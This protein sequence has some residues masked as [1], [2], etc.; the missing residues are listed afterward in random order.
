VFTFVPDDL[1]ITCEDGDFPLDNAL[2]IDACTEVTVSVSL[3]IEGGPCPEPYQ[4][5]RVFTATDACG[6][7]TS[8][9]QIIFIDNGPPAGCP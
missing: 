8:A 3:T 5:V 7:T 6:N 1:T 9:T 4:I 2:A